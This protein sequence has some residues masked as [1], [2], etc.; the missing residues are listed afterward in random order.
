ML[1]TS[2]TDTKPDF[3]KA[4]KALQAGFPAWKVALVPT[5]NGVILKDK[6]GAYFAVGIAEGGSLDFDVQTDSPEHAHRFWLILEETLG[7]VTLVGWSGVEEAR[8]R[9]FYWFLGRSK[10]ES[11]VSELSKILPS[12][13]WIV[14]FSDMRIRSS[15]K[16]DAKF[17]SPKEAANCYADA[18]IDSVTVF[19]DANPSKL[20]D[21]ITIKIA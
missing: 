15:L 19:R 2:L 12:K 6:S 5:G 7:R 9:L 10:P 14:L 21:E 17:L 8:E 11:F 3:N 18:A 4:K 13:T 16:K 20:I 1:D